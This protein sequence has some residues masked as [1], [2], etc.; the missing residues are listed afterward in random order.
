MYV[1]MK[2]IFLSRWYQA[3]RGA[4]SVPGLGLFL[5]VVFTAFI[6]GSLWLGYEAGLRAAADRLDEPALTAMLEEQLDGQR[7]E[8]ELNRKKMRSHLDALALRMGKL[9][10]HILRL[11]AL[12]ERLTEVGKL[13][14][15][16]FNFSETP[17][18]GGLET[19][20]GS[21]SIELSEL[22]SDMELL[23]RTLEDRE[24]KLNLMEDMLLNNRVLKELRPAGRPVK[25]GWISSD[26]GY[27]KDPFSGKK[28]FHHGVDIAGK[29]DSG[30]F[31]VA[32]GIVTEAGKKGG[33]GYLVEIRHVDGYFTRYG[34]NSEIFVEVGDLVS[35]GDR[36]GSMGSTGRSTGPHVHFEVAHNNKS[37]NPAKFLKKQ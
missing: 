21:S 11:D 6:S 31:A 1:V 23:T 4:F 16:E 37:V 17:A 36:I 28:T 10:S 22:L 26:Y 18:R 34:H 9:Q 3:G 7:R 13:D 20:D 25:K 24:Y 29:K 8:L 15:E 33:Y 14:P 5:G 19:P 30:V 35:K 27:R 32:S 2:T 12:G